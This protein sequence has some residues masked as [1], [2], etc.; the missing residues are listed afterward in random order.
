MARGGREAEQVADPIGFHGVDPG[1]CLEADDELLAILGMREIL[2]AQPRNPPVPAAM[3][4]METKQREQEQRGESRQAEEHGD[5]GTRYHRCS[6]R[7]LQASLP[8]SPER[9]W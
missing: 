4:P 3:P 6:T 5:F 1:Q 7:R 8:A 2:E 9:S